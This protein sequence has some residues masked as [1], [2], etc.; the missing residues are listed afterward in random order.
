LPP[1]ATIIVPTHDH[2]PT[3]R[4]SVGSALAQTVRDIEIFIVGDGMPEEAAAA[5]RDV[6]AGDRRIRLLELPK[7]ER[8]GEA[9]RHDILTTEAG[10][11]HVF[12]LSDDDLWL[13]EHVETL[14]GL[15][16]DHDADF[17]NGL[18]IARMGDGTWAH[19]SVDLT[20]AY[21][22][23]AMLG[24]FNRVGLTV[25]AHRLESYRRLSRGW[26]P[27]PPGTPTDL[28]MWQQWLSEPWVR[29]VSSG[30]PTSMNFP[31]P[32]RRGQTPE[33]R[34]RE[35]EEHLPILSDPGARAAWLQQVIAEDFPR[36]TWLA[37]HWPRLE[38]EL[39]ER[40]AALGWHGARHD[41]LLQRH[42][43][44]VGELER[45]RE[46]GAAQL[47]RA[48]AERERLAGE[49]E[50]LAAECERLAAE[51]ERL[52]RELD[53]VTGSLRWRAGEAIRGNRILGP[54][55]RALGATLRRG[56]ATPPG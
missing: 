9:Y 22:R 50:R 4:C 27:A 16:D 36:A 8:H 1:V 56:R 46:A 37:A 3:L 26:Q 20:I 13:P 28:Y 15:L 39:E 17:A 2:G 25:A 55:V 48:Q 43:W 31:S 18:T 49:R 29:F 33:E 30:R 35:L 14:A 40:E 19:A 7:G 5:A 10:G 34:L 45:A 54:P 53:V 51:C 21:H 38:R 52:Q 44:L 24:G 11:R 23:E 41:D 47:L 32:E 42:D 12:Y 6:A